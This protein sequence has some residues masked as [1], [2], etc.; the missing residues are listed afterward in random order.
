MKAI[1]TKFVPA[2]NTRGARIKAVA[3]GGRVPLSVSVPYE[4][5]LNPNE[6]HAAAARALA[7]KMGWDGTWVGGGLPD[8]RGMAFVLTGSG[9]ARFVVTDAA[10]AAA[11]KPSRRR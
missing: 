1:T 7:A 5:G 4:H 11:Q 3:E 9:A 2:T 10:V 6:N 8:G